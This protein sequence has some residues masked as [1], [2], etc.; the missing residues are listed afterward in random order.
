MFCQPAQVRWSD[1]FS[2]VSPPGQDEPVQWFLFLNMLVCE[3]MYL[4][5]SLSQGELLGVTWV[6]LKLMSFCNVMFKSIS[7]PELF[8]ETMTFDL[9]NIVFFIV[10]IC[11]HLRLLINAVVSTLQNFIDEYFIWDWSHTRLFSQIR[12]DLISLWYTPPVVLDIPFDMEVAHK[13]S[14]KGAYIVL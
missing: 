6:T 7:F 14:H 5:C 4:F 10:L 13:L 12:L 8:F 9:E 2:F 11:G 1:V 3:Y